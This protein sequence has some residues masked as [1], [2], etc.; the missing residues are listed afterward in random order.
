MPVS[1]AIHSVRERARHLGVA[2][3]TLAIRSYR[4]MLRRTTFIAVTGSGGKTTAKELIYTIASS[5][6]AGTKTKGTFNGLSAMAR[7]ILRTRP[8]HRF[9]VMEMGVGRKGNMERYVS[10]TRPDI[11]IMLAIGLD[12]YTAFRSREAVAEEKGHIVRCLPRHGTAILNADDPLIAA[13]AEHT[14]ARVVR[15]GCSEDV[16]LRATDVSSVWPDRLS[17][18]LHMDGK[19]YRIQSRLLGTQWVVS[20]L[21][22]LAVGRSLHIPTEDMM[23]AIESFEPVQG[24]MAPVTHSDGVTFICDDWKTPHWSLDY[25]V[26]F[27][28][29]ARASRRILVIGTIS[30]TPGSTS[31][32]YRHLAKDAL[33]FADL[34]IFV[35]K[36]AHYSSKPNETPHPKLKQFATV[37]E[38][39]EF[40]DGKLVA[41]DLV[42]IKGSMAADHLIRIPLHRERAIACWRMDCQ[43]M[44]RCTA[45]PLLYRQAPDA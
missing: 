31:P 41:G 28:R 9:C 3:I 37:R 43:R 11:G 30:D 38:A 24:R 5:Q 35:G 1:S 34:V 20:L 22:A 26:S 13:Q 27:L 40:L 36:K 19:A 25:A 14:R 23:R 16:D 39:S 6:G 21:A 32:K 18:T 7:A 4:R 8:W 12:H 44:T 45:C 42:L 17:F 15:I 29:E 33:A 2:T 10:M